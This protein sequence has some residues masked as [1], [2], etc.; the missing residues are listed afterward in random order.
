MKKFNALKDLVA[1][2]ETDAE[3]FYKKGNSA[4]GTRLRNLLKE[5]KVAALNCVR[6]SWKRKKQT[7]KHPHRII[8]SQLILVILALVDRTVKTDNFKGRS[9]LMH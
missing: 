8:N 4:A 9:V 1:A 7:N 2:A 6:K 3:K 5:V